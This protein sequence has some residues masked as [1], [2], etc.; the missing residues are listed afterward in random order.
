MIQNWKE[1]AHDWWESLHNHI[2]LIGVLI[3]L[4]QQTYKVVNIYL[5]FHLNEACQWELSIIIQKPEL[6]LHDLR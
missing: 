1:L 4:Y 6:L 3:N 2:T 5:S